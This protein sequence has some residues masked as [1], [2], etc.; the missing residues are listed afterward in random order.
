MESVPDVRKVDVPASRE[1][2]AWIQREAQ[3]EA[4]LSLADIFCGEGGRGR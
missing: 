1:K 3:R 2:H 4:D